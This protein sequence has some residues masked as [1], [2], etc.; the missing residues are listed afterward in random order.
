MKCTSKDQVYI[1]LVGLDRSLNQVSS[2]VLA[3]SPLPSLEE[4]YPLV[5][6]EA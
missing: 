5:R 4:A 3:I 6:C 2:C 1:F